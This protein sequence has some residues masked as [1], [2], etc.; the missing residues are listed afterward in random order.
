MQDFIDLI[1]RSEGWLMD[2]TIDYARRYGY[3]PYTSTLEEAWRASICG[4]SGPL[5]KA[6]TQYDEPPQLT[7]DE[8]NEESITAFGIEA[9][10]RHRS[11]GITLSLFMGLMKYY[12]QSYVDL[13]DQSDLPAPK[14]PRYR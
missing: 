2:Q 14:Q 7:A 13:I 9:A 1:S 3:M 5:I 4:I 12:R 8:H 10:R 6:L 11:R